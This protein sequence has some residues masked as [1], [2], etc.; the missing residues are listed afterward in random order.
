ME[1]STFLKN[2][3]TQ[4]KFL[5][6]YDIADHITFYAISKNFD[7]HLNAIYNTHLKQLLK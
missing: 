1:K 2:Y 3:L 4:V 6:A 5:A 7:I